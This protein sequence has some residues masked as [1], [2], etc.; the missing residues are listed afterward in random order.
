MRS[1]GFGR[2]KIFQGL[3]CY[4]KPTR[5]LIPRWVSGPSS[6]AYWSIRWRVKDMLKHGNAW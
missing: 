6:R 4:Q 2:R 1:I 3:A 5:Q